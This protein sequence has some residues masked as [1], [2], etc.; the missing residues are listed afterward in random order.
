MNELEK[1]IV[2][3]IFTFGASFCIVYGKVLWCRHGYKLKLHRLPLIGNFFLS[4]LINLSSASPSRDLVPL[5][6]PHLQPGA[7]LWI[8]GADDSYFN[9]KNGDY[10]ISSIKSWIKMGCAVNYL[11]VEGKSKYEKSRLVELGE[12]E[13]DF[14]LFY[15]RQGDLESDFSKLKDKYMVFH[16]T[17]LLNQ[18]GSAAI[19]IEHYHPKQSILAHDVEFVVEEEPN[20]NRKFIDIS[21]ELSDLCGWDIQPRQF[22]RA[23]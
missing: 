4:K 12:C 18:D 16:P 22:S 15:P 20:N 19:W 9:G 5:L 10:W 21:N 13:N 11:I 23:A 2:L 14:R 3:I 8:V 7:E 17:I 6:T 1:A